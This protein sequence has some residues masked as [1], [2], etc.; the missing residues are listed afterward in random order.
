LCTGTLETDQNATV[1]LGALEVVA[2]PEVAGAVA[3]SAEQLANANA[4]TT[5]GHSFMSVSSRPVRGPPGPQ[6]DNT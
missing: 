6:R 2:V 1:V 5:D 4:A 3:C